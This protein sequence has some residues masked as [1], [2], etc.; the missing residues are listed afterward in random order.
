MKTSVSQI[1][2]IRKGQF[3]GWLVPIYHAKKAFNALE[4]GQYKPRM[5]YQPGGVALIGV[6]LYV[7]PWEKGILEPLMREADRIVRRACGEL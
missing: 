5:Q 1:R 4:N 6:R 3:A 2:L 7:A